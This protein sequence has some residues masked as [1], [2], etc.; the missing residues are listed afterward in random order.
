[1]DTTV[2]TFRDAPL[3]AVLILK[4]GDVAYFGQKMIAAGLRPWLLWPTRTQLPGCESWEGF[5]PKD[6]TL[7][8][9]V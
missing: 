4:I 5:I 7:V 1:M 6:D 3:G 8:E 9:V 2:T